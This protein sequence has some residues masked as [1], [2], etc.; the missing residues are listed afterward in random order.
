MDVHDAQMHKCTHMHIHAQ[1]RTATHSHAQPCTHM[2][3][4]AHTHAHTQPHRPAPRNTYLT[5]RDDGRLAAASGDCRGAF[6]DVPRSP[7]PPPPLP[8]LPPVFGDT[9]ALGDRFGVVVLGVGGGGGSRSGVR[10]NGGAITTPNASDDNAASTAF[11]S[12]G[13]GLTPAA[14]VAPALAPAASTPPS[15]AAEAAAAPA[16]V[17]AAAAPPPAPLTFPSLGATPSAVSPR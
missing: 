12:R 2:H 14:T 15:L 7:P 5:P 6:G 17:V 1:P 4:H 16:T 10:G 11:T 3:T 8:A 9:T 13:T